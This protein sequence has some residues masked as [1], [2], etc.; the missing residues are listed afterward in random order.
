[1]LSYSQQ[2]LIAICVAFLIA[3]IGAIQLADPASLGVSPIF[4]NW[5]K[6]LSPGLGLLAGVL[7]KLQQP[8]DP[9]NPPPTIIVDHG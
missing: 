2:H 6:V 3:T 4:V 5:A 8:T 1:M 9:A 7:P